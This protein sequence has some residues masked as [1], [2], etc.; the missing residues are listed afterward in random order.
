M[1]RKKLARMVVLAFVFS[2]MLVGCDDK[3]KDPPTSPPPPPPHGDYAQYY[4]PTYRG[5]NNGS[6]EVINPTQHDMLLF[7]NKTLVDNNIIGGVENGDTVRINFS[8]E[9]DY[10]VGGYK[11][12][13]AVKQS[14]YEKAKGNSNVDYTAMV[15]YRN[16]AE[17]RITL[18]S[19]YDGNYQ[20]TAFNRNTDYPMELRKN[21]PDGEKIAFLARGETWYKV[22]TTSSQLFT[23]YPVWIAYNSVSKS[24]VPFCPKDDILS[25]L[26]IQ[27]VLPE[28]DTVPNYF[29]G[30]GESTITF[31]IDLPFATVQVQNNST[32]L[33]LFRTAYDIKMP[34]S[35]YQGIRSG[36]L[37]TFDIRS[38]GT[39][40]DLNLAIGPT[41]NL[42]IP[43][44]E[45]A[46]PTVNPIIENG[47][48]YTIELN[49]KTGANPTL[50]TSYTAWLVKG[51]Q[52]D[53]SQFLTAE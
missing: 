50:P 53:Q 48:I 40:L 51:S 37:E 17:F 21:T 52:I 30:G 29:P 14:E 32:L 47:W 35:G 49:L 4:E 23:V 38:E 10:I 5:N 33:A 27:P 45:E 16:G 20:F 41:Q 19:R 28:Q 11:I 42:I 18:M 36:K 2:L 34:Q 43:V 3:D 6:V 13:Y 46:N 8:D 31:E 7:K 39:G 1:K 25:V 22:K 12:I 15:T 9:T 24:I 26:T 44:R